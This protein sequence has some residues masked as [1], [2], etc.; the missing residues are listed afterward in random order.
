MQYIIDGHNLIPQ[1]AGLSLS[2]LD[3][4]QGLID[5][6]IP[7]CRL[8]RAHITV[9]FDQAPP[10]Q[11]GERLFGTVRAVFVPQS[12]TADAAIITY[13]QKLGGKARNYT[14]VSS[15]R[16]VAAAARQ[17]HTAVLSSQ[18]FARKLEQTLAISPQSTTLGKELSEEEIREW[19]ALFNRKNSEE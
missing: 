19:E 9:F 3:D 11:S 2:D 6:L 13:L 5:R 14:L 17:Y 1:V 8:K 16:M 15:D 7:F 4:E 18:E 12:Q 10:G